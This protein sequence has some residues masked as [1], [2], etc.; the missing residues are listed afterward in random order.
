MMSECSEYDEWMQ[1]IRWVN[2]VN[3]MSECSEYDEWMQWVLGVCKVINGKC[4]WRML[5]NCRCDRLQKNMFCHVIY[6]KYY[7]WRYTIFV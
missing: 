3:M 6:A 5:G 4:V 7:V 1:W 2:A